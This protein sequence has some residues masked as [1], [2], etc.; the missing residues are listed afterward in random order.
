MIGS[1]FYRVSDI[2]AHLPGA[3]YRVAAYLCAHL[4]LER[5]TAIS[6]HLLASPSLAAAV[7]SCEMEFDGAVSDNRLNYLPQLAAP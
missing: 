5:V 7:H 6:A 2:F 4:S 3:E 1:S